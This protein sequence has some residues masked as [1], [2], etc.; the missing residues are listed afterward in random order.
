MDK[1]TFQTAQPIPHK[2]LDG[3][4]DEYELMVVLRSWPTEDWS[5][6]F[7]MKSYRED[8]WAS[9]T[10]AAFPQPIQDFLSKLNSSSFVSYLEDLTGIQGLIPDPHF[11]GGGLHLI[12]PG[13]FLQRHRDFNWHKDLQLVR[14]VNVL[15]YLNPEWDEAWGGHLELAY[16]IKNAIRIAPQFGRMVILDTQAPGWHG[17]PEPLRCPA[18]VARRSIAAYYYTAGKVEAE[19]GTEYK[20]LVPGQFQRTTRDKVEALAKAWCPPALLACLRKAQGH[21]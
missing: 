6:W 7:H 2:I 14:R 13:G 20:E 9:R 5:D 4:F 10:G 16:P 3:V 17:H 11:H 12:K 8:K 1:G 19:K 21:G 15:I 18:T